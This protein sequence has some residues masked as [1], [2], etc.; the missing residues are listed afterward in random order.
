MFLF[1][2]EDHMEQGVLGGLIAEILSSLGIYAKLFIKDLKDF[3][4]SGKPNELESF[5]KLD[6][7]SIIDY[8]LSKV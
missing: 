2:I 1:S 3:T 5:Y 6:P 7:L 8:I 4:I